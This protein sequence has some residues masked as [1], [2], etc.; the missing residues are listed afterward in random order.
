M[1]RQ[2]GMIERDTLAAF[3]RLVKRLRQ[4]RELTREELAE[5][6]QV[7]P[8]L[9]SELERGSRHQP[10]RDTAQLLA[11]GLCLTGPERDSFIALARGR[12]SVDAGAPIAGG[13]SVRSS[14]PVAPAP[15][16]GRLKEIAAATALLLRTDVRLLTLTGP[17]GVGKTRLALEVAARAEV[18]FADGAVFVDLAPVDD[19]AIVRQAI[20]EAIGRRLDQDQVIRIGL[21]SGS[22]TAGCSSC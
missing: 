19:A 12:A 1:G 20:V 15:I 2:L 14:L 17:G 21:R 16:I 4:A 18:A 7:S 5:R 8:R 22:V 10:R 11:D 13:P 6:A 3:G 9:I